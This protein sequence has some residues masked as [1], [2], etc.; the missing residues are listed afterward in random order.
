MPSRKDFFSGHMGERSSSSLPHGSSFPR[1]LSPWMV[2]PGNNNDSKNHM[3]IWTFLIAVLLQLI[4][5]I[6]HFIYV[7][8]DSENI[9]DTLNTKQST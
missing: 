6:I 8:P 2:N 7:A 4:K 1:H 9:P 5:L 3:N